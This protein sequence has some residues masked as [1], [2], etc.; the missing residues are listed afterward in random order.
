MTVDR[1]TIVI[2]LYAQI[3]AWGASQKSRYTQNAIQEFLDVE[4]ADAFL[5]AC[6]SSLISLFCYI[7]N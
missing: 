7:C 5:M 6:Y 4:E 1:Y 2:V 3:A